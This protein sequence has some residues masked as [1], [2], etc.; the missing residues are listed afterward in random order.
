MHPKLKHAGQNL[1]H[2][3]QRV[4]PLPC[5]IEILDT[6]TS[7]RIVK[8]L[9][10]LSS[11]CG[12]NVTPAPQLQH[13]RHVPAKKNLRLNTGYNAKG[14]CAYCARSL[15]SALHSL[16]VSLCC[17]M[18]AHHRCALT[19][20]ASSLPAAAARLTRLLPSRSTSFSA[21]LTCNRNCLGVLHWQM[22]C[23]GF[24]FE[25]CKGFGV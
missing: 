15:S 23:K 22:L 12:S 21:L 19:T 7:A 11:H 2:F 1:S 8:G 6:F 13:V 20:S 5:S 3:E 25:F 10:T 9:P 16:A 17:A 24:R 14:H 18:R 4:Y